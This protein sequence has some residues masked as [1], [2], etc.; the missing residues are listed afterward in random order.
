MG[1]L[2]QARAQGVL[3]ILI[4][5]AALDGAGRGIFFQAAEKISDREVNM[6][7]RFGRGIV[8]AALTAQRAFAL[9]LKPMGNAGSGSRVLPFVASVEAVACTETGISA[10]ERA[11]TLRTLARDGASP[12]D[13]VS[14]GHIIPSIV[15]HEERTEGSLEALAYHHAARFNGAHAI[16][17]CDILN[18]EGDVGDAAHCTALAAGLELPLLIRRGASAVEATALAQSGKLKNL[19]VRVG[20]LDLGQFA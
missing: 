16:A 5:H 12:L 3:S 14:P 8:G 9:G 17:W 10:A 1:S 20:G 13:L 4:D 7:A 18:A 19:D 15:P 6:M 11:L 2:I